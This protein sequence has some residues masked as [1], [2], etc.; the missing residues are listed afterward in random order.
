[1]LIIAPSI[2]QLREEDLVHQRRHQT[3]PAIEGRCVVYT[4]KQ[5]R[6]DI[7][8]WSDDRVARSHP[9]DYLGGRES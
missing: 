8:P 9:M 6:L 7:L 5:L 1:M 4:M 3:L 2:V